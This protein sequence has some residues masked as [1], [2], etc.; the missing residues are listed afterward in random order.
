MSVEPTACIPQTNMRFIDANS[1]AWREAK[2]PI[3]QEH[4][5]DIPYPVVLLKRRHGGIQRGKHIYNLPDLERWAR[6]GHNTWPHNRQPIDWDLVD[7]VYRRSNADSSMTL[8]RE[9]HPPYLRE[10]ENRLRRIRAD[11]RRESFLRTTPQSED[12]LVFPELDMSHWIMDDDGGGVGEM[13]ASSAFDVFDDISGEE[14]AS[15]LDQ[16]RQR[17]L[18]IYR[19]IDPPVWIK[20]YMRH[21]P[22]F[23]HE[24]HQ[25][26]DLVMPLYSIGS[27]DVD[28]HLNYD[29]FR[30][31][32]ARKLS[33]PASDHPRLVTD[34]WNLYPINAND[35]APVKREYNR[36]QLMP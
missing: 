13:L 9:G 11:V 2:C 10:T 1:S 6:T 28:D 22:F 4:L 33:D 27:H 8:R 25:M 24:L 35:T 7:S 30:L 23:H 26:N 18:D 36:A 16:F 31:T 15:D 5:C 29:D 21:H 12:H 17:V 20:E 34:Y 3:S 32:M 19:Q 14:D